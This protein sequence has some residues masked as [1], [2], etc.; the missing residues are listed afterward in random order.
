DGRA[1]AGVVGGRGRQLAELDAD[2]LLAAAQDG[3]ADADDA[4]ADH[5]GRPAVVDE[6]A[7]VR[8]E[9]RRRRRRAAHGEPAYGDV[10][11]A[12]DVDQ[13]PGRVGVKGRRHDPRH[14]RGT[15]DAHRRQADAVFTVGNHDR[16]AVGAG[17]DDDAVAGVGEIDGGLDGG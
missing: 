3:V 10:F 7:E 2:A 6:N 15:G 11:R 1:A 13:R 5:V 4:V 16:L 8:A 12:V 9:G 17:E 14:A